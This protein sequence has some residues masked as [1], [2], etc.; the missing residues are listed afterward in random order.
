MAGL[1]TDG[2][3]RDDG[4]STSSFTIGHGTQNV[5]D[6]TSEQLASWPLR[7]SVPNPTL[8]VQ[9]APTPNNTEA[10]NT[11]SQAS[12][13]EV[14][15]GDLEVGHV[16]DQ[17]Q[18]HQD[19]AESSRAT[20]GH[21]DGDNRVRSSFEIMGCLTPNLGTNQSQPVPGVGPTLSRPPSSMPDFGFIGNNNAPPQPVPQIASQPQEDS[22]T[23][24]IVFFSLALAVVFISGFSAAAAVTVCTSLGQVGKPITAGCKIWL[25]LSMVVFLFSSVG[26]GYVLCRS[27]QVLTEISRRVR[28]FP[29]GIHWPLVRRPFV[30]PPFVRWPFVRWP[31]MRW[32]FII[33]SGRHSKG[34]ELDDLENQPPRPPT[35]YPGTVRPVPPRPTQAFP[36]GRLQALPLGFPVP[37]TSVSRMNSGVSRMSNTSFRSDPR[38]VSPLSDVPP[39][40]PPKDPGFSRF[41]SQEPLL[42]PG[43]SVDTVAESDTRASILTTLCDAVQLSNPSNEPGRA[44][45]N[46]SP[47]AMASSPATGT[48]SRNSSSIQSPKPTYPIELA[49]PSRGKERED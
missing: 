28:A 8:R 9:S 44:T 36:H 25:S 4:T 26:L 21:N 49:S 40:P 2:T 13:E 37:P 7:E 30:R 39:T 5:L 10:T 1:P 12:V 11:K 47:L 48:T 42:P 24:P 19:A 38:S 16:G 43:V 3:I 34:F 46:Y 6:H 27:P 15:S 41:Q 14:P 22:I 23:C 31:L 29:W 18:L 20:A 32:P 35:P 45:R 17:Q 33:Q